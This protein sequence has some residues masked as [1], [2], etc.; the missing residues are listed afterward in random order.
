MSYG[1]SLRIAIAGL[2]LCAGMAVARAEDAPKPAGDPPADA[3]RH[4]PGMML[5]A[6]QDNLS[7]LDLTDA[8]KD[9]VKLLLED[10]RQKLNELR[11]KAGK[12]DTV[13]PREQLRTI[14]GDSRTRLQEILTP[15]QQTKLR[16]L[17]QAS[18][19]DTKPEPP[20]VPDEPR[21]TDIKP[22][23]K[24]P[25]D[26]TPTDKKPLDVPPVMKEPTDRAEKKPAVAP[27]VPATLT[28][29]EIGQPAPDLSLKT[30]A[31]KTLS[32][33]AYKGKVLVLVFG[34]YST[35]SFRQRISSLDK[36]AKDYGLRATFLIVYTR[37]AH[38][39]GEW[40]VARNKEDEIAVEQP[41]TEADRK[42]QAKQAATALKITLPVL[43]DTMDN[44]A[45]RAFGLTPNGAVIIGRDGNIAAF[46]R[47]FEPIGLKQQLDA[48]V[49]VKN[50]K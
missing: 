17:M 22:A 7:K 5:G 31:D 10:T 38:A 41:K 13:N 34:S 18:T 40:E 20:K 14:M 24:T 27:Q 39:V 23:D 49:A 36:L 35:P 45:A 16:D 26:K 2:V 3:P 29:I 48:A 11:E 50:A 47:W 9:K 19:T 12:D 8:Q 32:L 21:P 28:M 1:Q 15:D 37:E 6:L 46:Q 44:A 4:K 42:A 30:T 33:A 25:T 43:L